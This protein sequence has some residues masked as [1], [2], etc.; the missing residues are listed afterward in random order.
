M[1]S[2]PG[3]FRFYCK[4]THMVPIM[5]YVFPHHKQPQAQRTACTSYPLW[6]ASSSEPVSQPWSALVD[7]DT[8]L[9]ALTSGQVFMLVSK[10]ES[11][12][13]A[14]HVGWPPWYYSSHTWLTKADARC[15]VVNKKENGTSQ[16]ESFS[17]QQGKQK[18]QKKICQWELKGVGATVKAILLATHSRIS[19]LAFVETP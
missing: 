9:L 8:K 15:P 4:K 1:I 19:N 13:W 3:S 17:G 11:P 18:R 14:H 16:D 2:C 7:R 6:L 5:V 10:G 12:P